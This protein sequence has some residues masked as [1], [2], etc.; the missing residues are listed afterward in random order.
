MTSRRHSS[1]HCAIGYYRRQSYLSIANQVGSCIRFSLQVLDMSTEK[2]CFSLPLL[3]QQKRKR[4]FQ[5]KSKWLIQF[6]VCTAHLAATHLTSLYG[7]YNIFILSS[8]TANFV[9]L[10]RSHNL[11]LT[12]ISYFFVSIAKHTALVFLSVLR[13]KGQDQDRRSDESQPEQTCP[14]WC[15]LPAKNC[16]SKI[17]LSFWMPFF[18]TRDLSLVLSL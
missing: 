12:D 17:L 9:S 4:F 16:R 2:G 8:M 13:K 14:F 6:S 7:I 5:S 11:S 18:D 1:R 15:S 3:Q 10:E